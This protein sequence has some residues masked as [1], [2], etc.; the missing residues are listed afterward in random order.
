MGSKFVFECVFEKKGSVY[1]PAV[2]RS[3]DVWIDVGNAVG[4]G[5]Y[6]HHQKEGARSAY[7]LVRED[8]ISNLSS[9]DQKT[10]LRG[11]KDIQGNSVTIFVHM[12]S[13]PDLDCLF[14]YYAIKHYFDNDDDANRAFFADD[15]IGSCF[16]SYIDTIDSGKKKK[17]DYPTLYAIF[18][19]IDKDC[20]P[21]EKNKVVTER[22]LEL[23]EEAIRLLNEKSDMSV[24]E[25]IDYLFNHDFSDELNTLFS[26][27]IAWVKE[28]AYIYKEEKRTKKIA[29]ENVI[30]YAT[31]G[32]KQPVKAAIWAD[33]S[34]D[35]NG[36]IH[37]RNEGCILTVVLRE[38]SHA[39]LEGVNLDPIK[40]TIAINPEAENSNNYTLKPIAH[41]IEQMEQMR[42]NDLRTKTG[43]FR[44]DHSHS[45]PRNDKDGEVISEIPF[46]VTSDPWYLSMKEDMLS[47]PGGYSLIE[48]KDIIEVL[49]HNGS[50]VKKSYMID[51]SP[52]SENIDNKRCTKEIVKEC[53]WEDGVL[54]TE[55]S[56]EIQKQINGRG[57]HVIWAALDASLISKDNRILEA[58]CLNLVG[59]P[60]HEGKEENILFLDYRTCIYSDLDYTIILSA[61][62]DE[63]KAAEEEKTTQNISISDLLSPIL[64]IESAQAFVDS[65]IIN[66]IAVI[67]KQRATLLNYSTRIGG[68]E[69]GSNRD[70]ERLNN[71]ILTF[72]VEMQ[73]DDT[74]EG[75]AEREIYSFIK[76]QQ[77]IEKLRTSVMEEMGMVLSE[78]R[79]RLVSKFNILSAYAVPFVI[80]ATLFQ[81]GVFTF[82]PIINLN[83]S[84]WASG[85]GWIAVLI[86][87]IILVKMFQ[88]NGIRK[89]K[90]DRN[91]TKNTLKEKEK[92]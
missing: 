81:M 86:L 51:I 61:T 80:I 13:N 79:T 14:S 84:N 71:D 4:E 29:L 75:A 56:K 30:V 43:Y 5:L 64:R 19:Y 90:N 49:R 91:M 21:E 7:S 87:T 48:Y 9:S 33:K 36:Y 12:H 23:I 69:S 44:R 25:K 16:D 8:I 73:G 58:F 34:N 32:T 10:Y 1:N 50:W 76:T 60:F 47:S 88:N 27:E 63:K 35:F 2:G 55:W 82:E 92:I 38:R 45:R 78:S 42:E 62:Y 39:V 53:E 67:V 41:I 31:D 28:S 37:A 17:I 85:L 59:K 18:T 22:G 54:I 11:I 89:R 66:D 52:T 83:G 15:G 24:S 70:I 77:E 20:K 57:H 46:S 72:S 74:I 65:E 68:L 3:N 6:D 26:K 40:V